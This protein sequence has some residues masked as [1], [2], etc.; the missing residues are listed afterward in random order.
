MRVTRSWL[1]IALV[2]LA[3]VAAASAIVASKLTSPR[4]AVADAAAPARPVVTSIVE[5]RVLKAQLVVRG[6]VVAAGRVDVVPS[7]SSGS[8]PVV[9]A[10]RAH[11]GDAVGEGD[12]PVVVAGRPVIVLQGA[13][14]AYRSLSPGTSGPDVAQLQGALVRLGFLRERSADGVYGSSTASAVAALYRKLGFEPALTSPTAEQEI[15]EVRYAVEDAELALER[16]QA[17][18]A[19][20]TGPD[21]AAAQDGVVDAERALGRARQALGD[22]T[23]TTG[24]EVPRDEVAFVPQVPATVT[25]VLG[26]VGASPESGAPV[27]SLSSGTLTVRAQLSLDQGELVR[28]GMEAQ[29]LDESTN[30]VT[31][32]RVSTVGVVS[33]DGGS[34][35]QTEVV[36]S[37]EDALPAELLGANVRV[38]IATAATDGPVLV[39]PVAAITTRADGTTT[40]RVIRGRTVVRRVE[41]NPG[42]TANGFVAVSPVGGVLE[43]GDRV[44][45][46]RKSE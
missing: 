17:T 30:R 7:G 39:I 6:D 11:V 31:A 19:S 35:R 43:P 23:R 4:Q 38:T 18:L 44:A 36:L 28:T 27:V 26:T 1:T 22:V 34:D 33:A 32:A 46:A 41:V 25:N 12:V 13:F 5:S 3:L 16:A 24:V 14:P 20:A 37:P 9:T 45:V 2:V 8:L 21:A 10:V 42:L 40:V 15:R 29:I